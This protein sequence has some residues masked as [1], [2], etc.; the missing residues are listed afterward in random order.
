MPSSGAGVSHDYELPNVG[1]ELKL[2]SLQ[3]Q[4]A[5]LTTDPS[6]LH[7]PSLILKQL[8]L[9]Y[10]WECLPACAMRTPFIP[11]VS[12]GQKK[13]LNPLELESQRLVSYCVGMGTKPGPRKEQPRL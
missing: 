4:C 12:G 11:G 10:V 2:A 3:E 1:W 9:F 13:T 8:L 6:S 5:L 7:P